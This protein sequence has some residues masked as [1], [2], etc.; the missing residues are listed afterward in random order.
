MDHRALAL[1]IEGD[2]LSHWKRPQ[3]RCDCVAPSPRYP[4]S[5]R[6]AGERDRALHDSAALRATP[7]LI[8]VA[9]DLQQ[10]GGRATR[11]S[12]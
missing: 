9:N 3:P 6:V 12:N 5:G 11:G 8:G 2:V 10:I 4:A 1:D 7:L